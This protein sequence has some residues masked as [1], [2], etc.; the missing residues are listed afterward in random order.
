MNSLCPAIGL[1][2]MALIRLRDF[3]LEFEVGWGMGIAHPG[4][5]AHPA[6]G[7]NMLLYYGIFGKFYIFD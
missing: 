6:T 5:V 1:A 7:I 3:F 4:G 2:L